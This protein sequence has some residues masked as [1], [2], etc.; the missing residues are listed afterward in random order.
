ML[1][2]HISE[3]GRIPKESLT[4]DKF[5]E[6]NGNNTLFYVSSV[7]KWFNYPDAVMK[8]G[9][10]ISVHTVSVVCLL[11]C[12]FSSISP[13]LY[14]TF[15]SDLQLVVLLSIIFNLLTSTPLLLR[16]P[17][18]V[19]NTP[20]KV[21]YI[22]FFLGADLSLEHLECSTHSLYALFIQ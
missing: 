5:K 4:S 1:D 13:F 8:M 21:L 19:L 3:A 11:V 10:N 17:I 20:G 6:L 14:F 16:L 12:F 18:S 22:D 15:L 2:L 9:E 7:R